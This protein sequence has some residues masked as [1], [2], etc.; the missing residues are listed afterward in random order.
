M[1]ALGDTDGGLSA[2]IGDSSLN[3]WAT[4]IVY[5]ATAWLCF[6]NSRG[7]VA[8]LGAV[9][10]RAALA[11]SRRR[12]W[13]VL[14]ALVFLLG[15]T[16]QLD[17][18]ALLSELARKLLSLE[19]QYDTRA[20]LQLAL[21]IAIGIFGM[22]GLGSALITFRRAEATVLTAT[23]AAAILLVLTLIRLISLH[24]VDRF[25]GQGVPHARINNV[26]EIGALIVIAVASFLFWRRLREEGESARLRAVSIQER[27]RRATE[28]RRSGRS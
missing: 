21:V 13:M 26:I 8:V 16:R 4:F 10:G 12:F 28:K 27:R 11:R 19:G 7:S 18:Q 2:V 3:G 24:D 9:A 20:G 6:R 5:L 22:I 1:S 25:L 23:A 15:L 14:A 17:I